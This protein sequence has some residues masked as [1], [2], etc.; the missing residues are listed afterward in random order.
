MAKIFLESF[1]C[2]SL[3]TP[4][5]S[6]V[7]LVQIDPTNNAMLRKITIWKVNFSKNYMMKTYGIWIYQDQVYFS[8]LYAW[9][10]F[11]FSFSCFTSSF[12]PSNEAKS[13]VLELTT[14]YI[15]HYCWFLLSISLFDTLFLH[16]HQWITHPVFSIDSQAWIGFRLESPC[17]ILY[18]ILIICP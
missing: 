9:T 11:I 2:S 16:M 6:S 14:R 1:F 7:G 15:E 12:V 4:T 13:V 17:L 8:S 3:V 18:A 10:A 5:I